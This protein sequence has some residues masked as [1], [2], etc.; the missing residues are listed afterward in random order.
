MKNRFSEEMEGQ[1]VSDEFQPLAL[2]NVDQIRNK[3]LVFYVPAYQRGYR[4]RP[5]EIEVLIDDLL[6]FMNEEGDKAK[7]DRCPF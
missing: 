1:T 4:W 7:N 3:E 5:D 2:V 6:R